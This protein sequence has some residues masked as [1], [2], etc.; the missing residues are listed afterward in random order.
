MREFEHTK[1]LQQETAALTTSGVARPLFTQTFP[2]QANAAGV[3][4]Q[5]QA[6]CD[7]TNAQ[8]QGD[9]EGGGW[10]HNKK[11][12]KHQRTRG[13]ERQGHVSVFKHSGAS[14]G[15]EQDDR[16]LHQGGSFAMVMTSAPGQ[17]GDWKGRHK[18]HRYYMPGTVLCVRRSWPSGCC[19]HPG[20]IQCVRRGPDKRRGRHKTF[21][22][23]G[24]RGE[25][26][27]RPRGHPRAER[28]IRIPRWSQGRH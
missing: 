9:E 24:I 15:F 26:S 13:E 21:V 12:N 20:A 17:C 11:N 8:R 18:D 14:N 22:I 1:K 27:L 23:P 16:R 2:A 25:S 4:R 7:T 10:R 6:L 3:A 19:K 28:A 5:G